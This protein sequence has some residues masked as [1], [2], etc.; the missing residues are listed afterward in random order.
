MEMSLRSGIAPVLA[1]RLDQPVKGEDVVSAHPKKISACPSWLALS[2]D[3]RSFVFLPD[4]AETVRKI[5]ELSIGGMGSY[6]IGNYLDERKIPTFGHSQSWD[7]TTI[8]NML[9]SRATFGEYR[10]RSYAGGSKK[11]VPVGSAVSNYYPAVIDQAT[12]DAAQLARRRNLAVGRG[13]K[14]N[15]FANIFGGL[16]MC[17]YCSKEV[18]F[19]RN[20]NAKSMVCS[21]VL[22]GRGCTRTG[23]S[24]QDF[25]SKVLAFLVHPAL[26][27]LLEDEPKADL[28]RLI[29]LISEIA[30][31][32][33][34]AYSVRLDLAVLLK[35]I[36]AELRIASAGVEPRPR[37]SAARVRND[38][39][40]RYFEL[41][42]RNGRSYKSVWAG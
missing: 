22:D 25:E 24:Y 20:G 14:G 37:I 35:K 6:A 2:E 36:V 11:G 40:G 9:R 23:W 5:F 3:R 42:L 29:A 7:H 16:T 28:E 10:A 30:R 33:D 8:D 15:D 12:F 39:P 34:R 13:R 31:D 19:H 4:K 27:Q 17:A 1:A 41:R 18:K 32:T 26:R 38:I 21:T